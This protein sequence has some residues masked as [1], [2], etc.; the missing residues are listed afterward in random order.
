MGDQLLIKN[1]AQVVTP[2]GHTALKGAAM[3]DI[4][5]Y[6]NASVLIEDGRITAVGDE[7]EWAKTV[8]ADKQIDATGKTVFRIELLSE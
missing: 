3:K 1:A 6:E 5:I 2:V 8:P 7:T 4:K